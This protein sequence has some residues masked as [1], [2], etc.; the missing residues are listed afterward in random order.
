MFEDLVQEVELAGD[1]PP[2]FAGLLNALE[3]DLL[4]TDEECLTRLL[5]GEQG[6]QI[7]DAVRFS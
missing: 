4:A 2:L 5:R 3:Q 1:F 6:D 7:F